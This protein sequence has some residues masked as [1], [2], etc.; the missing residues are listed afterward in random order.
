MV[1]LFFFFPP[2]YTRFNYL[3]LSFSGEIY[4]NSTLVVA[5][6]VSLF[7]FFLYKIKS[8]Q[9]YLFLKMHWKETAGGGK[10]TS[11]YLGT[12]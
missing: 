7:F 4:S 12:R 2:K 3:R 8:S 11:R 5:S 1:G 10:K 9:M 6:I